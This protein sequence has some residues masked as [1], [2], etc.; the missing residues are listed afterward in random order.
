MHV[1]VICNQLLYFQQIE[2]FL[3][4]NS[5][6]II[7]CENVLRLRVKVTR[8]RIRPSRKSRIRPSKKRHRNRPTRKNRILPL[9]KKEKTRI[10]MSRKTGSYPRD[11]L[12]KKNR[13]P[14]P[15]PIPY[16][17]VSGF[18]TPGEK[19]LTKTDTH[20]DMTFSNQGWH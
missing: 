17:T 12:A 8:I 10:K 6:S 7:V 16:S 4:G 20:L 18:A 14:D 13:D 11:T 1:L 5:D 19:M 2:L 15:N 3:R 9:K